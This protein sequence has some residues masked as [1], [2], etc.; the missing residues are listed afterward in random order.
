MVVLPL[1]RANGTIT[2]LGFTLE[3]MY[4]V[5]YPSGAWAKPVAA[6]VSRRTDVLSIL[7]V[8]WLDEL[9]GLLR[10]S[11]SQDLRRGVYM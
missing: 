3:V 7:I 1:V 8:V 11:L 9:H 2:N 5:R 4:T 6:R 10:S